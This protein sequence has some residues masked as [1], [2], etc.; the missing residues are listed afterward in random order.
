MPD[1]ARSEQ[2]SRRN[3]Y[4]FGVQQLLGKATTIKSQT[5]DRHPEKKGPR[6]PD[7]V[8]SECLQSLEG[9]LATGL[10]LRANGSEH[11][12]ALPQGRLG[13]LLANRGHKWTA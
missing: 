8:Q 10:K 2:L 12:I 6:R 13:D 1:P 11:F 4:S 3:Q 7:R 9:I 5:V